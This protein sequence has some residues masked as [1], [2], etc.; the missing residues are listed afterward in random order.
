[1]TRTQTST[2]EAL[3]IEFWRKLDGVIRQVPSRCQVI[4]CMDTTLPWIGSPGSRIR[5]RCKKWAQNGHEL[6]EVLRSNQLV[7]TST[8]GEANRRCWTW[9]SPFKTRHRLD[10]MITRQTDADHGKVRF[11]YRMPV[12]LSGLRVCTRALWTDTPHSRVFVDIFHFVHTSH[13]GS[14]CRSVCL[15]KIT[16][17]HVITCLSVCC[18]LALSSSSPSRASTFSLTV[19]LF[20]VLLINFHVVETAE[21]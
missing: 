13:C 10:Y 5:D 16:L 2:S 20:S 15:T 3:R 18:F 9:L 4:L 6:L 11:D 21:E 14:R 17:A 12:G 7:S 19:Y 8:H 1:M